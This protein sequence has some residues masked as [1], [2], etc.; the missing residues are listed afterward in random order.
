ME[1]PVYRSTRQPGDDENQIRKKP[2]PAWASHITL[3]PQSL[4]RSV[5]GK[6]GSVLG[7]TQHK[8]VI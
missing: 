7:S 3:I 2:A 6:L 5:L 4:F 8:S 1:G